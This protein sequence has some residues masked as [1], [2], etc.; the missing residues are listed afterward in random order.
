MVLIH[1]ILK[2]GSYEY[3]PFRNVYLANYLYL[4]DYITSI[5][6]NSGF[7]VVPK[8]YARGEAR[9]ELGTVVSRLRSR[10]YLPLLIY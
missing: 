10:S 2:L 1:D 6:I 9:I 5:V 7:K 8:V 3:I 4:L